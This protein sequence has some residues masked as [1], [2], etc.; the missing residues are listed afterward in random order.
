MTLQ[1]SADGWKISRCLCGKR[2]TISWWRNKNEAIPRKF[3]LRKLRNSQ[4]RLWNFHDKDG[5]FSYEVLKNYKIVRIFCFN[6]RDNRKTILHARI[7]ETFCSI[8]TSENNGKLIFPSILFVLETLS[9]RKTILTQILDSV[10]IKWIFLPGIFICS[11]KS[12]WVL[13]TFVDIN[14][15]H[16]ESLLLSVVNRYYHQFIVMY[17]I[18]MLE[19]GWEGFSCS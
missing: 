18:M 14:S 8:G 3:N 15:L 11:A 13:R 19:R 2:D 9:H 6:S 16:I 4:S 5:L 17:E 7:N 10:K 1:F 12:S